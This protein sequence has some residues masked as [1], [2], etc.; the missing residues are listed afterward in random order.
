MAAPV[1]SIVP[2]RSLFAHVQEVESIADMID[3]LNDEN[4]LTPEAAEALQ[5]ALCEAVAGTKQKVDRVTATLAAFEAGAS[6]AK[7]EAAR[8]S[9]RAARFE[10]NRERLETFVLAV[11]EASKLDRID[12]ETSSVSR[13]KNPPKLMVDA[14]EL[15]PWDYMLVPDPLPDPDPVPD[16]A[17]LKRDLK[18]GAVISGVRLVQEYRLLRS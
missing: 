5:F 9:A 17:A 1:L 18:G 11:L 3:Q 6:A 7:A 15:I 16:K 8:L 12:G 4:E 14:V 10:R 2:K 13:R